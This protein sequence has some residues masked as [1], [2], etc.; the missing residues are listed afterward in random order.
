VDTDDVV[1]LAGRLFLASIFLASAFGKITNFEATV[2][3]MESHG[4]VAA[5]LL[6]AAAAAIEALG[7][8]SLLLGFYVRWGAA[9]LTAFVVVATWLF[10][11]GPEQ[12]IHLLKNLA[13]IG[14]LLQVVAFGAGGLSLEGRKRSY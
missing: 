5:V 3:Y 9:V 2:A 10:H 11:H 6:C 1:A 12:R 8:V 4:V 14:G 13:I 7:G